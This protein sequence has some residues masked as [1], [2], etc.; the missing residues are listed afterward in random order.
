MEEGNE[1]YEAVA[2]GGYDKSG[3]VEWQHNEAE[4]GSTDDKIEQVPSKVG[5]DRDLEGGGDR[6]GGDWGC[7]FMLMNLVEI[8]QKV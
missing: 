1:G 7:R 6:G 2:R 4:R 8:E 5:E 3:E